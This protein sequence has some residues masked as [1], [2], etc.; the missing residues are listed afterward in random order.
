MT[1]KAYVRSV[2]PHTKGVGGANDLY[3]TFIEIVEYE[4]FL[5]VSQ[6]SVETCYR[7]SFFLQMICELFNFFPG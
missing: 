6:A 2:D 4:C 7:L 1:D 5:F 3:I